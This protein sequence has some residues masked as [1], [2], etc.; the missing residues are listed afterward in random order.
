MAFDIIIGR[1]ESDRK[2]FGNK[3]VVYIGKSYVKMGQTTS[4]SNRLFLDVVR[5]HVVYVCG[6]RGSGKSYTLGVIAEGIVDLPEEIKNNISILLI[7]TMG[8]Y[9]TMKYKNDKDEDL[10][11]Q[12]G[13]EGRPL[14]VK[15]YT[16]AGFF[17]KQKEDGIPVDYSFTIAPKELNAEDWCL[18]FGLKENDPVSVL[19]ESILYNF[20]E[21]KIRDY[22]LEDIQKAV[23]K[24][25]DVDRITRA[26]AI[27][28]LNAAKSWGI[29]S[30]EATPMKN[31]VKGGQVSV[32]DISVFSAAGGGGW[33]VKALVTGLICKK[34]FEERM[35]ERKKEEL[36]AI[37]IGYSYFS[38]KQSVKSKER[39]PQSWIVLDEA[40]E[41]LPKT[42]KN[43]ATDALVTILREGRQP[44]V[45]LI[46]ATQQPGKIHTDVMT[47]S[48]VVISHR[49]TAKPDV[50][51]LSSMMQSYLVSDL[52]SYL[53]NL[54][55]ERGAAVIL[56][57]N[58]ERIYP[59][60]IRPRF[61][62]HGG[63]A[64]TAIEPKI[65]INLGLD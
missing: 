9:W 31:L 5:S 23:M 16:P 52:M 17:K 18:T 43:A 10:L 7:D 15:I 48:D 56:D 55:S 46:L 3:G 30:K 1:N 13:L 4:L 12:W 64:P 24:N 47:Q 20:S 8:I 63:E 58:S 36:E 28:H 57:D 35:L 22:S 25:K 39:L 33:G 32:I 44:G 11:K 19:I 38:Q 61:T 62:W 50:D 45:S 21:N 60:R 37:K 40:H 65:E 51:A 59:M 6:K 14:D 41:F 26:N 53:N 29:F 42:G 49:I 54:P 2:K 34:I 27:N